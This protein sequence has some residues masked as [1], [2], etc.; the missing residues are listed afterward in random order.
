VLLQHL[1][2]VQHVKLDP[3][4]VFSTIT[5][6]GGGFGGSESPCS[7]I[8]DGASG[9]SG[10]GW[11]LCCSNTGG[12]GNTPPVSPPQ[13]NNGG[14]ATSPG[15]GAGGRWRWSW[16]EL[17]NSP[18]LGRWCRWKWSNKFNNRKC[19]I[20]CWWRWWR[21]TNYTWIRR[22]TGGLG[23]GGKGSARDFGPVPVSIGTAN[24]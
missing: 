14:T 8:R 6:T 3:N 16:L 19:N 11:K 15:Y 24:S 7:G 5:S 12:A 10:G 1:Y 21:I 23:G 22:T 17:V 13:G 20:L 4:S 2:L 9:G 18:A